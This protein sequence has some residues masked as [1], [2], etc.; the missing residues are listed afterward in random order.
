MLADLS[1][2]HLLHF[3]DFDGGWIALL[4][5]LQALGPL[6]EHVEAR[7][8]HLGAGVMHQHG[9][10][11]PERSRP[12]HKCCACTV[13]HLFVGHKSEVLSVSGSTSTI[14]TCS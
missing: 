1:A 2:S 12:L 3:H 7:H 5:A 6:F 14:V 13:E 4:R 10:Y 8:H 11:S 9:I